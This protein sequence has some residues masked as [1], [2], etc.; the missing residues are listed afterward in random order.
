MRAKLYRTMGLSNEDIGKLEITVLHAATSNT[1]PTVFWFLCYVFSDPTL[2]ENI[3]AETK[4]IVVVST[5]DG[6]T[7]NTLD[8]SKL[9][10]S[11]PW[12]VAAWNEALR[13]TNSQVSTRLVTAD[14][15]LSDGKKTYLLKQGS[16][17]QMPA[18]PIHRSPAIWG[19]DAALFEPA[20]FLHKTPSYAPRGASAPIR[21]DETEQER[22]QRL[23]FLPFGG[24]KHLC[25]GRM[26]AFAEIL[27][28]AAALC[29]GWEAEALGGG[30]VEAPRGG[31]R[32]SRSRCRRQ[33]RRGGGWG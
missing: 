19:P 2:V 8:V 31:G 10:T 15:T 33:R 16:I 24:G 29:R 12:L 30:R 6:I 28:L 27:A 32:S 1:V 23:A 18:G 22:L 17:L 20:R 13:L 14:T 9:P 11:C 25:P 26:F 5:T 3:T 7:T 21:K 4:A